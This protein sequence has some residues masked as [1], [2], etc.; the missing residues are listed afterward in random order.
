M[1]FIFK[2]VNKINKILAGALMCACTLCKHLLPPYPPQK[3]FC[4]KPCLSSSPLMVSPLFGLVG[5][6]QALEEDAQERAERR[7]ERERVGRERK[8]KGNE[9]FRKEEY[10]SAV[11]HYTEAIQQMPWDV[12]L[13]TNRA[14]VSSELE[15]VASKGQGGRWG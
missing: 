11:E 6:C 2:Y 10:H 4:M 12:S 3:K 15:L 14:L 9:A 13:Y 7:K 1:I 5:F 8:R